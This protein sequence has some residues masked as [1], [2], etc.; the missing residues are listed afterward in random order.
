M[1]PLYS[2]ATQLHLFHPQL[3][4]S[5]TPSLPL[6]NTQLRKRLMIYVVITKNSCSSSPAYPR[7][8][9]FIV[10]FLTIFLLSLLYVH[11]QQR[12][13]CLSGALLCPLHTYSSSIPLHTVAI[14]ISLYRIYNICHFNLGLGSLVPNKDMVSLIQ[15]LPPFLLLLEIFNFHHSVWHYEVKSLYA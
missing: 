5:S 6:A 9:L 12:M 10:L 13:C 4:T 2:P 15:Q 14:N 7:K 1:R 11:K 3:I 8:T